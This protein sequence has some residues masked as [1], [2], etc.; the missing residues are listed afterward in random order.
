M[1]FILKAMQA[2]FL[3]QTKPPVYLESTPHLLL[4]LKTS[5]SVLGLAIFP[6]LGQHLSSETGMY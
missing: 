3:C 4:L 5:Q 6:C 1:A 2:P